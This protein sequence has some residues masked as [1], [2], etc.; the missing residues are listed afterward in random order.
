[1]PKVNIIDPGLQ[2][3]AGHHADID[4][5]LA[6]EFMRR[7]FDVKIFSNKNFSSNEKDVEVLNIFQISPY[8]TIG[9]YHLGAPKSRNGGNIF[10]SCVNH[11][12]SEINKIDGG[13]ITIF[14]TL[15]PCQAKALDK[16]TSGLGYVFC[17]LHN[18]PN[19][20]NNHGEVF[21]REGFQALSRYA[22]RMKVG[23]LEPELVL[24]YE[25]L[26]E[27]D[28]FSISKFPIPHDGKQELQ[29]NKEN[30]TVG[31]LGLQRD[32]KGLGQMSTLLSA[33]KNERF[34]VLLHDSSG[35]IKINGPD[36]YIKIYGYVEDMTE[37]IVKCDVVVLN[38][39]PKN[40]RFSGS[41]I[42]WEALASAVPVLAPFGTTMSKMIR[43]HESGL[44]FLP[45]N[46]SSIVAKLKVIRNNI[47]TYRLHAKRAQQIYQASNSTVKLVD[48]ITG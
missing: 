19:W 9:A 7:N 2:Q 43:E 21:W 39:D 34:H 3:Y 28:L 1:M 27:T 10:N 36:D 13:D 25:G 37:L 44:C 14:P 46:T 35:K 26:L 18:H 38:Y 24:E 23:V 16:I 40:Y 45:H 41:G 17:I 42:F 32:T 6:R 4:L 11:I 31:I 30:F 20:N 15:F 22:G 12:A 33:L 29:I 47:E 8:S 5:R 48:L